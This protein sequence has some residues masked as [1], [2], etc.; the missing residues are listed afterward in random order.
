MP[1]VFRH[2]QYILTFLYSIIQF[3]TEAFEHYCSLPLTIP[4]RVLEIGDTTMSITAN[5]LRGSQLIDEWRREIKATVTMIVGFLRPE[6]RERIEFGK[7]VVTE[8]EYHRWVLSKNSFGEI[9]FYFYDSDPVNKNLEKVC[10]LP[11]ENVPLTWVR[12]IHSHLDSLVEGMERLFPRLKSRW[13]SLLQTAQLE[14]KFYYQ[15]EFR[16]NDERQLAKLV[17]FTKKVNTCSFPLPLGTRVFIGLEGAPKGYETLVISG[18]EMC[19][20][21]PRP[22][23]KEGDCFFEVVRHQSEIRDSYGDLEERFFIT[24]LRPQEGWEAVPNES[25]FEHLLRANGWRELL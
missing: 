13:S 18:E 5:L 20:G 6:D 24:V 22:V 12:H 23:G 17:R 4:E 9:K 7:S 14:F 16:I 15:L 21:E 3:K 25:H 1:N 8:G 11:G 19:D 2:Y 10:T